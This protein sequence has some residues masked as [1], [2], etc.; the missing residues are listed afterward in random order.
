[1]GGGAFSPSG[2]VL[3]LGVNQLGNDHI[4]AIDSHTAAA[5]PL[6]LPAKGDL[7]VHF[8]QLE[9]VPGGTKLLLNGTIT[10]TKDFSTKVIEYNPQTQKQ[11]DVTALTFKPWTLIPNRGMRTSNRGWYLAAYDH[12]SAVVIDRISDK[13]LFE[14]KV[15][16]TS[17]SDPAFTPD[18]TRVAFLRHPH[19]YV[20]HPDR[21][22]EYP[23]DTVDLFDVKTGRKLGSLDVLA[24]GFAKTLTSV[25][26]G[27][28]GKTLAVTSGTKVAVFDFEAAFGL[29]PLPPKPLP[30]EAEKYPV[31]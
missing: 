3:L 4:L 7:R 24:A 9:P 15:N 28:D 2:E 12:Q 17:F 11:A 8:E 30:T 6:K 26:F 10:R 5:K 16:Q 1:M 13:P 27:H 21:P 18:G 19:Y 20:M 31:E 14:V 22:D 25:E 29:A 23:P